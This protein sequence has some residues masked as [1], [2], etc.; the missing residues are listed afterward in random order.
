M[1]PRPKIQNTK[2]EAAPPT[3][4]AVSDANAASESGDRQAIKD[5]RKKKG[6]ASTVLSNQNSILGA[7][8][9]ATEG[10]KK[11]LG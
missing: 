10:L 4:T 11:T 5:T 8:N 7:V 9:Q 3:P 2:V 6:M 1:C